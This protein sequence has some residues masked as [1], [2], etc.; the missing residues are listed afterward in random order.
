MQRT[1]S[2]NNYGIKEKIHLTHPDMQSL[3]LFFFK[4]NDLWMYSL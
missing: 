1:L 4:E 2:M 3:C